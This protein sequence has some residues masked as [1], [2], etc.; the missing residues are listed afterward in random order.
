MRG[1][2]DATTFRN[3]FAFALRVSGDR[4]PTGKQFHR[5]RD[6]FR[7][8]QGGDPESC[9]HVNE[10]RDERGSD[11]DATE[12]NRYALAQQI[13][14]RFDPNWSSETQNNFLK[15][16]EQLMNLVAGKAK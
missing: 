3:T 10:H 1:F 7:R 11:A 14:E 9:G 2:T 6:R 5:A 12:A 4:F 8:C 13:L 15:F 16:A